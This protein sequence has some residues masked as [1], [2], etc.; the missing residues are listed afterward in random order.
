MN[1][2]GTAAASHNGQALALPRRVLSLADLRHSLNGHH[3]YIHGI[4]R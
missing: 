1:A 4:T 2:N 3:H